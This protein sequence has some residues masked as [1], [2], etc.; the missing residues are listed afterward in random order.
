MRRSRTTAPR[1]SEQDVLKATRRLD[2]QLEALGHPVKDITF[3]AMSH[4]HADHTANANAFAG[5]TWI[6]QQAEYD[7]MFKEGDIAD[8]HA[9]LPTRR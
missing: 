7:M 2:R 3:V 4:Y 5:S 1:W 8:P 9:G 6:V